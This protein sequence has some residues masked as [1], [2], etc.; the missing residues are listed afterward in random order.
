MKLA[1]LN[2]LLCT[3]GLVLGG[4]ALAEGPDPCAIDAAV[5]GDGTVE[6]S[7]IG[8]TSKCEVAPAPRASTTAS[9]PAPAAP[10]APASA[11]PA[12]VDSR[13]AKLAA[14][15]T[16]P[17]AAPPADQKD[18]RESYHDNMLA[19]APGTTAANPAVSR[20][21]KMMD[22]ATYQEKVLNGAPPEAGTGVAAP[23]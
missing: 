23:Q 6:L 9:T 17:A 18:R 2:S 19:G 14:P 15:P 11:P 21:Y 16:D 22:K 5:R 12:A 8:H 4:A 1:L 10:P 20:R 3:S 13:S 7:N